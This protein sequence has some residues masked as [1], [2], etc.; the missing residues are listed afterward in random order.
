MPRNERVLPSRMPRSLPHVVCTIGGLRLGPDADVPAEVAGFA[1]SW[2]DASPL[3]AA[4]TPP[5][6]AV[7]PSICRRLIRPS[8]IFNDF[9]GM[10]PPSSPFAC[11][12]RHGLYNRFA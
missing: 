12:L 7:V 5:N 2:P 9:S 10:L 4:T 6:N 1:F 3:T 8:G 11:D